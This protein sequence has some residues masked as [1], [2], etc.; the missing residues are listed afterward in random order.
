MPPNVL[1]KNVCQLF[2]RFFI[3]FT[4]DSNKWQNANMIPIGIGYLDLLHN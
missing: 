2:F 3:N 4:K 1:Y